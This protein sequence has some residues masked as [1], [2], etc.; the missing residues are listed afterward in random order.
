MST[1][2][3]NEPDVDEPGQAPEPSFLQTIIKQYTGLSKDML[4]YGFSGSL[5]Q[6]ASLISVTITSRILTVSQFGNVYIIYATINYFAILMTFQI[7]AGLWR[8][9]YE[10]PDHD[11]QERQRMVSSLLWFI[12]GIGI[13]LALVISSFG[14]ELSIRLFGSADNTLAIQLAVL[15]L[16]VM[17]VYNLFVGLQRLKRRPIAYLS[18]SLGYSLA[19]LLMIAVFVGWIKVG[20]K[21]IFL[22]QLIAYSC[23]A[24][25]AF[26]LGRELVAFTFSK[27]W[28]L[29][30]AAYGLPMLPGAILS[31]SLVAINRYYLNAFVGPEQVGYYTLASNIALAM[32]LIVSSFTMAWQPFML[33]NLRNPNSH[34]LYSLTLNYYTLVTLLIGAGLAVFARE[35]VLI[36]S[37]PAYLPA[38]G[39]ISILVVRQILTEVDMITGVGI[40]ISKKTIFTSL[41]LAIGVACNLLGDVLL[42]PRWGMYG[43]ALAETAGVFAA[44]A[45][46]FIIS[47]WLFQVKWDAKF[48]IRCSLGYLVVVLISYT[49]PRFQLDTG[50]LFLLKTGLLAG[51]AVFLMRLIDPNERSILL[52]IPVQMFAWTRAKL[53]PHGRVDSR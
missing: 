46:I 30:M 11:L 36:V 37:T 44:Q 42:A 7:G 53:L 10:V 2:S 25:A 34:R 20:L 12:L 52:K 45:V 50:W 23:A 4:I 18:I 28:F 38:A 40:V 21:G 3:V 31:W 33:A 49:L 48:I 19:Y 35:I 39:L 8:Y 24:L 16:P 9:Y 51:Y 1:Q 27:D 47:N 26:W 15:S 5:G 22:A 14:R 29:K 13:P 32:A 43:A 6:L 17:A 41:A